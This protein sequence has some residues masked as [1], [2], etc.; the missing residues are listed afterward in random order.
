VF[1][2]CRRNSDVPCLRVPTGVMRILLLQYFLSKEPEGSML[3]QVTPSQGDRLDPGS[4]PLRSFGRC[5]RCSQFGLDCQ[6]NPRIVCLILVDFLLIHGERLRLFPSPIFCSVPDLFTSWRR[7]LT[8]Y[9]PCPHPSKTANTNGSFSSLG[10]DQ[11][12]N[13]FGWD[14]IDDNKISMVSGKSWNPHVV[15]LKRKI[16]R[17][18]VRRS[19]FTLCVCNLTFTLGVDVLAHHVLWTSLAS[20][21]F[22]LMVL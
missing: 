3:G 18:K 4:G 7:L 6:I 11:L 13:S 10:F 12:T 8:T 15:I 14:V 1:Q 20:L 2:S 5:C 17:S 19:P 16:E 22:W 9:N 21:Y